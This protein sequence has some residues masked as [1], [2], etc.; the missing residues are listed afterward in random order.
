[1]K[2]SAREMRFELAVVYRDQLRAIEAA[3]DRGR[4]LGGA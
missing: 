2:Q 4:E 1:M 3:R